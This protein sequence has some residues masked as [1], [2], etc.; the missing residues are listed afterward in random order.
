MADEKT[1]TLIG[2]N[3]KPYQSNISGTLGGH[4]T[5]KIYGLFSCR[6]ALA[7]IARGGY[8]RSRVSFLDEAT[9]IA[10]GYRPCA[11]CTPG[12]LMPRGKQPIP[13]NPRD[14]QENVQTRPAFV[15]QNTSGLLDFS[16]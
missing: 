5:G 14:H 8:V 2:V 11:T 7:A 12:A 4:R 15:A 6:S 10:A 13:T 1:W 16:A 3:G 9:V